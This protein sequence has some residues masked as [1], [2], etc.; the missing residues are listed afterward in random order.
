[1]KIIG[2]LGCLLLLAPSLG[3]ATYRF[4]GEAVP[5][6]LTA[7]E[8]RLE[9]SGDVTKEGQGSL[10]WDFQPGGRIEVEGPMGFQK[11]PEEAVSN[12]LSTFVY[13]IYNPTGEAGPL[14]FTFLKKG[15]ELG[16][17]VMN[18]DFKGWRSAWVRYEWDI[19]E[20]IREDPDELVITAPERSGTLFFDLVVTSAEM[21][22]RSPVPDQQVPFVGEGIPAKPGDIW[23][24]LYD[25]RQYERVVLGREAVRV[26]GN[27]DLVESRW[28]SA[29]GELYGV[30]PTN[31]PSW[32][33]WSAAL[34]EWKLRREGSQ[35]TG[36]PLFFPSHRPL[37][38]AAGV[39]QGKQLR[40][41]GRLLLSGSIGWTFAEG[42]ESKHWAEA[43]LLMLDHLEEQG[44]VDGSGQGVLHHLGYS[45]RELYRGLY[46]LRDLL[47]EEGRLQ[48]VRDMV[49]WYSGTGRVVSG[50][51]PMPSVDIFNT[52]L[53]GILIS[54]LLHPEGKA[55]G[56]LLRGLSDWLAESI[57]VRPGIAPIFKEDGSVYHHRGHYPAYANGGFRGLGPVLF[58]LGGTEYALEAEAFAVLKKAL[59]AYR[60]HSHRYHWPRSLSG[61]HPN[62]TWTLEEESFFWVARAAREGVDPDLAA[63][64]LRLGKNEEHLA[65]FREKGFR[66]ESFPAGT[67]A[68]PWA[69]ITIHRQNGWM[70]VV[71]GFS[72]YLWSHETY[73]GA[74]LYGRYLSHGQLELLHRGDPVN[75]RASG[76]NPKGWDWFH[77][78]GATNPVAEYDYLRADIRNLDDVSGY[79]EMLLSREAFNGGVAMESGGMH[80]LKLAGHDKYAD[81][82]R[83]LKS[84]T[85]A[86][87]WI[88]CLGSG[89]TAETLDHPVHTTLFQV[90]HDEPEDWKVE[91]VLLN[92]R[93]WA[94]DGSRV[95]FVADPTGV[96]YVL[97]EGSLL[98]WDTSVHVS[99]NQKTDVPERGQPARAWINHGRNPQDDQY[100]YGVSMNGRPEGEGPLPFSILRQDA[101]AHVV[102]L[103]D[104]FVAHAFFEADIRGAG[105]PASPILGVNGP[106]LVQTASPAAGSLSL[107]IMN[108]DLGLFEHDGDQ[109]SGDGKQVEVSIYSRPWADRAAGERELEIHLAG[110]WIPD[111]ESG[112]RGLEY[113]QNED[114]T[115][116]RVAIKGG[117]Q[118]D[119]EL[120]QGAISKR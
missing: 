118:K 76:F 113:W 8:G 14:T 9:I 65:Y 112:Q 49:S 73:R 43:L 78:P 5:D 46:V 41:F 106:C 17:F 98:E 111:P 21:D 11:R 108:P 109:W 102:A 95:Q 94:K 39:S 19:G 38:E 90:A 31:A 83:A 59:L 26:H 119:L 51:P 99:P 82:L 107:S 114:E 29:F 30:E 53:E 37:L 71:R 86:G 48:Q 89:I 3:G 72:R 116:L 16:S 25:F 115:F 75:P 33:A 120:V 88:L 55:R 101:A 74:N 20:G 67:L 93:Y 87:D 104:Q 44:W 4:E 1:M 105:S 61:R 13:W 70:A 103:P 96:G 80:A 79:E 36:E 10:R 68:M 45:M 54:I 100:R 32:E 117:A 42:E 81:D 22:S 97:P 28:D 2:T 34:A 64:Y 85:F 63:A 23:N 60:F 15:T 84:Y 57:Q 12:A 40:D 110:L 66:A 35:V 47:Q 56:V 52:Q 50:E 69:G 18:L 77:L 6:T 62:G 27:P 58:A 91:P 24:R 92:G 7:R